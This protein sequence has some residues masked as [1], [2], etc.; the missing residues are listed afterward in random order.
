LRR[1][2]R[3]INNYI[4]EEQKNCFKSIRNGFLAKIVQASE[5][6]TVNNLNEKT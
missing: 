1:G 5:G 6:V 2:A 3:K 4:E